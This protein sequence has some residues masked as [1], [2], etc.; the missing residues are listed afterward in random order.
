MQALNSQV[1]FTLLHLKYSGSETLCKLYTI[2][3]CKMIDAIRYLVMLYKGTKLF[4][5]LFA[6]VCTIC[7]YLH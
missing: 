3:L 6:Q 5:G 2:Q 7:T 1:F 4:I